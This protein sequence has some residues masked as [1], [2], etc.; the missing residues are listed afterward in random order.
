MNL[1]TTRAGVVGG[2]WE[3]IAFEVARNHLG[4]RLPPH[5]L[6]MCLGLTEHEFETLC[7]DSLFK[8]RVKEFTKELQDNGTSFALKAQLQAEDLLKTQYRIAKDPDTPPSVAVAAIAA[9]VRWAGFDRK[10]GDSVS[11][12]QS[13]KGPRISI[14]INLGAKRE[15]IVIEQTTDEN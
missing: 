8:R 5:E 4:P 9:T 10:P 11:D 12:D 13:N 2:E 1:P 6:I 14:N 3:Q 15:P 7:E